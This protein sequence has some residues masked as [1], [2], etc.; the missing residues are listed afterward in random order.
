MFP[1]WRLGIFPHE[2]LVFLKALLLVGFRIARYVGY[3]CKYLK[4]RWVQRND[5]ESYTTDST[6]TR[7]KYSIIDHPMSQRPYP[8]DACTTRSASG[9]V[10]FREG[11]EEQDTDSNVN[12]YILV[13]NEWVGR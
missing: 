9:A 2:Q 1:Y 4:S 6:I 7:S 8:Q 3:M 13:G 12:F 5:Q 11:V 10:E